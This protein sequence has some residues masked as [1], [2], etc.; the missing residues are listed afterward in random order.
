MLWVMAVIV[1]VEMRI[2]VFVEYVCSKVFVVHYYNKDSKKWQFLDMLA[3]FNVFPASFKCEH[4]AWVHA[5]EESEQSF[6][7]PFLWPY[8]ETIVYIPEEPPD[9]QTPRRSTRTSKPTTFLTPSFKGKTYDYSNLQSHCMTQ[10]S[11]KRG[12]KM[13]GH[14]GESAVFSE[15]QQLHLR[16]VFRPVLPRV[17][18]L[19]E[20]AIL[21]SLD[22]FY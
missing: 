3:I 18:T 4:N 20:G 8:D 22:V 2:C 9:T 17:L 7:R 19:L 12:L 16:N 10:L 13:W 6:Y 21:Q 14:K 1:Q 15:L 11:M 5:V